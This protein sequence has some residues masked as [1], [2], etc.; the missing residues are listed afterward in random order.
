MIANDLLIIV[1][2]PSTMAPATKAARM[3]SEF[4][5]KARH[6]RCAT[7]LSYHVGTIVASFMS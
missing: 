7:A 3:G 6:P 5:M 2:K 4:R 1:E